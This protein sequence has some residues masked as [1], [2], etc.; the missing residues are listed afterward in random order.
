MN[1]NMSIFIQMFGILFLSVWCFILT[2]KFR[3]EPTGQPLILH[4]D[5]ALKIVIFF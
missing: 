1:N 4:T 2:L 3:V 5:T